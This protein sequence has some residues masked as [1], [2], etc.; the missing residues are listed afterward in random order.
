MYCYISCLETSYAKNE[1][2]CRG[3]W[4]VHVTKLRPRGSVTDFDTLGY[5]PLYSV[6]L[7]GRGGRRVL[8]VPYD[9]FAVIAEL[10]CPEGPLS[11]APYSYRKEKE[12]HE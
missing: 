5:R 11:G 12:T 1:N 7:R 6:S 9:E 2:G 4:A 10:R 3:V 8:E